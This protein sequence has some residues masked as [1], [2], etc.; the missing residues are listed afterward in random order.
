MADLW[1][2]AAW[3]AILHV[4]AKESS[5]IRSVKRYRTKM[6]RAGLRLVQLWIPDTRARGF[7]DECRRQSR[8]ASKHRRAEEQVLTWLD[9]TRD[10]EGWTA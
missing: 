9:E 2:I 10:T 8:V 4:M 1:R 6:R 5:T 3:H 7:A